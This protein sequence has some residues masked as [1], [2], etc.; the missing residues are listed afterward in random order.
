MASRPH[1]AWPI[2]LDSNNQLLTCEQGSDQDIASCMATILCWPLG[3]RDLD[4]EFGI[5]TP[6]F[7]QGGADLDEI[8]QQLLLREPRA[9]T[10]IAD[11]QALT[12]LVEQVRVGFDQTTVGAQQ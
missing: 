1:I 4:P 2:Q 12:G 8:K 6:L 11:E 5:T 9:A 10:T 3:A 7:R